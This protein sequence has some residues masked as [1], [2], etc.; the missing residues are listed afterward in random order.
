MDARFADVAVNAPVG[1]RRLFSYAVPEGMAMQPGQAVRVPFGPR[2][3]QGI[4]F[5]LV[6][7]PAVPDVRPIEASIGAGPLLALHH[8]RLARWMADHYL[9]S[10]FDAAALW[11]HPGFRQRVRLTLVPAAGPPPTATVNLTPTQESVLRLVQERGLLGLEEVEDKVGKREAT[12]VVRH[13]AQRKLVERQWEWERPRTGPRLIQYVRLAVPPQEARSAAQDLRASRATRRAAALEALV[14]TGASL[15]LADLRR[16][17]GVTALDLDKL[18]ARGLIALE[19]Q[20]VQRDPLAGQTFARTVAPPL[21]PSQE[22]ACREIEKAL[23][24]GR[25][26]ASG[27]LLPGVFLLHGVTASGKTEVY[28]QALEKVVALGKKGIVLVPEISLTPQTIQRFAERFPG[29]IAV[30]HSAL[31][32]GEQYD[33]WWRIREGA[34]DAVIGSRSAIFAPQ[35]DVGLIVVDEEHEWTYKQHDALP[36]YHARDVALEMARLTGAVVVLGSA[37]PDVVTYYKAQRGEYRLLEL[38]ERVIVDDRTGRPVV[39]V[40]QRLPQADVVDLRE[41]LRS[42]NR[43]IFS[44][45]LTEGVRMA[46]AAREQVILFLNRRGAS[47]FVQC[48]DCGFVLRC[49]RCEM[50]LTYHSAGERLVCHQCNDRRLVPE[51]CPQCGSRRI[52]Y[53]GTGTQKVEEEAAQTFS[54]ARLLRWDRDVTAGRRSHEVILRRFLAHEADILV[55]TQMIAKGL[56]M[57]LVTLVGVICADI[58]LYSPDYRSGERTFQV[59]YQV[60]GRAG[61]GPRG[62]RVVFQTYSPQHYA[63][64]AAARQDYR[65]FFAQE[66]ANR[67][68]LGYPPYSRLALLRYAH[69]NNQAAQKEAGRLAEALKAERDTRGMVVDVLGPAPGFPPRLRGRYRWHVVLRGADPADLV[70]TVPIP[71]G[72]DV[73][74]DPVALL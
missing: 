13:L 71:L 62:G 60:A 56:H 34:F 59:L 6:D 43:S 69:A 5:D 9:A 51:V 74:I 66:I 42:G 12:G 33:E 46:L 21:T 18:T 24:A 41:E 28:L 64:Q 1:P 4:V 22:R 35:P 70:K 39:R 17:T 67:R 65:V 54:G 49:R 44:R 45:A 23:G 3:V 31:S 11:A 8:L 30:L 63:V 61:R 19:A 2:V 20:R 57:P 53:L 47:T 73:D 27:D 72:W 48:R 55:G 36:H 15:A 29:R 26:P 68:V 10:Y 14:F 7:V 25:A 58:G 50:P 37:T 16:R 32:P 40:E 38:P 52:R